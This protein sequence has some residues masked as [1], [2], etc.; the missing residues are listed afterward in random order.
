MA[1]ENPVDVRKS[2]NKDVCNLDSTEISGG[3]YKYPRATGTQSSN[4]QRPVSQ[5]L[6]LRQDHPTSRPNSP[7]PDTIFFIAGEMVVVNLN[8]DSIVHEFRS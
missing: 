8:N 2:L 7:E 6:I 4:L 5:P 1:F 3:Q